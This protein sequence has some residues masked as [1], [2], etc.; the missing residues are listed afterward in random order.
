M[1]NIKTWQ[2]SHLPTHTYAWIIETTFELDSIGLYNHEY[3]LKPHEGN[4]YTIVEDDDGNYSKLSIPNEIMS[5][6]VFDPVV[7]ATLKLIEN[8]IQKANSSTQIQAIFLLGGFGESKYLLKRANVS[9]KD[10]VKEIISCD[11]GDRAAMR[12]AIYFGIE[13]IQRSHQEKSI[14]SRNF[15]DKDFDPESFDVLICIG[16]KKR[17]AYSQHQ[18]LSLTGLPKI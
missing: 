16:K 9:F 8:Q 14:I 11:N 7:N 13:G 18:Y 6:S 4:A 15:K 2:C 17:S 12:G 1:L 3:Q 5:A 10:K